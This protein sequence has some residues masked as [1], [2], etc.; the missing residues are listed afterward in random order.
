VYDELKDIHND[1]EKILSKKSLMQIRSDEI[2]FEN[3]QR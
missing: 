3:L 2:Y 1:I